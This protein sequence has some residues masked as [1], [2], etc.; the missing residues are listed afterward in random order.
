MQMQRVS[1]SDSERKLTSLGHSNT[2]GSLLLPLRE[3]SHYFSATSMKNESPMKVIVDVD[4]GVDDAVA[5][6]LLL[7]ADGQKDIEILGITCSHGNTHVNNVCVN[8]LR[9]LKAVGRSDIPVYRGAEGPLIVCNDRNANKFEHLHGVDGFGDV[10]FPYT[11]SM[12]LIQSENAVPALNRIVSG[13]DC[14]GKVSLVCLAPLTNIAL[15]MKTYADFSSNL[16]DIYVMG[17]NS[18]GVGNITSAGEFN[19]YSD[20]EAAHIVLTSACCPLYLL[21]WETCLCVDISMEWRFSILGAIQNCHMELL[22]AVEKKVWEKS[23]FTTWISCDAILA[24]VLLY[25]DIIIKSQKCHATVE[26]HGTHTRGQVVLDHLQV[27]DPNVHLIEKVDTSVLK[28]MLLW[29]AEHA[30]LK[31]EGNK[32]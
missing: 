1:A 2:D 11:P 18:T 13:P 16:K 31:H 30:H 15:T 27:K 32:I 6:L 28:K 17:G 19:F 20:P 23:H 5:L 26:L 9:L 4:A 3:K 8:V 24:A 22:N 21:P 10:E 7:S 14:K 12:E 25:P 29:A